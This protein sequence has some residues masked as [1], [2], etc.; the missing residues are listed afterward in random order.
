[1]TRMFRA[2]RIR[3]QLHRRGAGGGHL[4]FRD[5]RP[6][7][8]P[9]DA[10]HPH[11]AHLVEDGAVRVIVPG[12]ATPVAEVGAEREVDQEAD[13]GMGEEEDDEAGLDELVV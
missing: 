5:H 1:M 6:E 10:F 2:M 12:A 13:L 11:E 4:R 9:G 7:P 3:D 8:H